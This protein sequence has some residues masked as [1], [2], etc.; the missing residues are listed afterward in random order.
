[1]N[2]VRRIKK[3]RIKLLGNSDICVKQKIY[4]INETKWD[5][6]LLKPKFFNEKNFV[7]YR[8]LSLKFWMN[9]KLLEAF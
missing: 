2:L 3:I 7:E 4:V 8:E 9:L 1:M 5:E 6:I